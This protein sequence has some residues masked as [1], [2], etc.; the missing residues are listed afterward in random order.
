MLNLNVVLGQKQLAVVGGTGAF[1]PCV[2]GV[3][4][5]M[6]AINSPGKMRH[7]V[8]IVKTC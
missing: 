5:E 4:R 8:D 2:S 7:Q 6:N 3:A 1:G